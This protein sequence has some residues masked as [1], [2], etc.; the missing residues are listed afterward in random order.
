MPQRYYKYGLPIWVI[1]RIWEKKNLAKLIQI[2]Y[3]IM[4]GFDLKANLDWNVKQFFTFRTF[5][6]MKYRDIQGTP[7]HMKQNSPTSG[8]NV[9]RYHCALSMLPLAHIKEG[10][11]WLRTVNKK[12]PLKSWSFL[13]HRKPQQGP[14]N[15]PNVLC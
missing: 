5:L 6:L 14:T 12:Q 15:F 8:K 7:K 1:Q 11:E 4:L 13:D 3:G 10:H 2:D 9:C